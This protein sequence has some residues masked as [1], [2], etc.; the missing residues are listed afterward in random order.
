MD[1]TSPALLRP[2]CEASVDPPSPWAPGGIA[3]DGGGG[4]A[5]LSL[6]R[7]VLSEAFEGH[8][9]AAQLNFH[10][11]ADEVHVRWPLALQQA[12]APGHDTLALRER[13]GLPAAR[14][15]HEAGDGPE[16][17]AALLLG[18]QWQAF[19]SAAELASAL[20]IRSNVARAAARTMLDFDT[21][22][23]ERPWACGAMTKSAA[24]ICAK[25]CR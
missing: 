12:L 14:H 8:V 22:A 17:A 7:R 21:E 1:A 20:R 2:S 10:A 16:A 24:F 6:A 5:A 4:A 9:L 18:P 11:L 19:P 25:A 13:L 23:L 3:I 15:G